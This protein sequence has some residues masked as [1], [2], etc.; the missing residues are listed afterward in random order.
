MENQ[1]RELP[2]IEIEGTSFLVDVK[3][4]QL[5]QRDQLYLQIPG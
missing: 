2:V 4:Q 5:V 1:E 3:S